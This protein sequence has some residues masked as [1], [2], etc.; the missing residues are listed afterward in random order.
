MTRQRRFALLLLVLT[1]LVAAWFW[2]SSGANRAPPPMTSASSADAEASVT[3]SEFR[4]DTE[5]TAALPST[6]R[7]PPVVLPPLGTPPAK[8]IDALLPAARS[9][10][11]KAQCRLGV[12]LGAC[13]V[14]QTHLDDLRRTIQ[15]AESRAESGG[16]DLFALKLAELELALTERREACAAL[17]VAG[18]V[19]ERD[20][21]LDAARQGHAEA[22][23]RYLDGQ[24][25]G[26]ESAL[27]SAGI[28]PWGV[29]RHPGWAAWQRE[30]P[31]IANALLDNGQAD[32][33]FLLTLAY[34]DDNT[35]LSGLYPNDPVRRAA[36]Q[37]ALRRSQPGR[38]N[39]RD[40]TEGMAPSDALAARQEADALLARL[41]GG[42]AS[43]ERVAT[44][45]K[46]TATALLP[47]STGPDAPAPCE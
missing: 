44:I 19:Q 2:Q 23:L 6:A 1:A 13:Q 8:V 34:S 7:R 47:R 4:F 36:H 10:D 9:G 35:P 28:V 25:L 26:Y 39:E 5:A 43:M 45:F 27:L 21:L 18:L 22:A 20:W 37:I 32:V 29:M 12:E 15:R 38:A 40:F 16:D 14:V 30:S 17:D 24:S 3:E 31:R 42:T 46:P 11:A 33:L 41:R